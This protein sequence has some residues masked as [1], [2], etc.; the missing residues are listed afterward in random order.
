M[1]QAEGRW[2]LVWQGIAGVLL[3]IAATVLPWAT[4]QIGSSSST[5]L[6]LAGPFT[7]V[8][9]LL[10]VAAIALAAAQARGKATW[11]ARASTVVG[12]LA[13]VTSALTA[14]TRI[15]H[16]NDLIVN[17]GGS[18]A[19]AFGSG[20]GVLA[21]VAVVIGSFASYRGPSD[22]RSRGEVPAGWYPDPY[23]MTAWRWWDGGVW[24]EHVG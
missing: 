21:G 6:L 24:T 11:A 1:R 12:V 7:W 8:L 10:G 22:G 2:W 17:V 18:S 9:I 23:A 19:Y 14:L 16:A 3:I 13:T 15:A 5:V 20:V 4:C